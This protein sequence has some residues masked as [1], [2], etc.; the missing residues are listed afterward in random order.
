MLIADIPEPAWLAAAG[1]AAGV[2]L[3]IELTLLILITAALVGGI[4]FGLLY[5]HNKVVPIL[6]RYAP[7][8]EQRLQ[9]TDRGSA[10]FAERV[11]DI[12]AR[13]VAV[14]EGVRTFIRPSNG[15]RELPPGPDGARQLPGGNGQ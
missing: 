3:I 6:T 4:A 15:H 10:R 12:H 1:Q 13:T 8:V 2:V 11:I 5:V 7:A 14:R 9:A